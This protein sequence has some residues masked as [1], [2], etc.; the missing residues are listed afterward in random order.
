MWGCEKCGK[1]VGFFWN[2][3]WK[4]PSMLLLPVGALEEGQKI[5]A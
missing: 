4:E 2:P 5:A 1:L 3:P